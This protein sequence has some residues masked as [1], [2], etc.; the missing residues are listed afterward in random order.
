MAKQ[1]IP[2]APMPVPPI[3]AIALKLKALGYDPMPLVSGKDNPFKGWPDNPNTPDDI[4]K[5]NGRTVAL[6]TK[7]AAYLFYIDMDVQRQDL[8][9]A[10]LDKIEAR[11]PE[12]YERCVIRHSGA[13]K[14][15]LI[16]R[17][18]T[19]K[20]H[21]RTGRYGNDEEYPGGHR[22]ELFTSNDTRYVAVWG[23]HSDGRDYGFCEGPSL[24]E[25]KPDQL[26]W[27]KDED[28]SELLDMTEQV[29]IDAGLPKDESAHEDLDEVLYNLTPDIV[30]S[31]K[32]GRTMT[33]GD[34]D[35][36]IEGMVY[37]NSETLAP[38]SNSYRLKAAR[39]RSMGLTI[40][41][42]GNG[43][44]YHWKDQGPQ[45]ETL[46]P[47]LKQL[48]V[49]EAERIAAGGGDG[50]G[51]G[52]GHQFFG[53]MGPGTITQD[54]VAMAFAENFGEKL[55]YCHDTG[56]WYQ[57]NEVYWKPERTKLAFQYCR[58][59]GRQLSVQSRPTELKEVRKVGFA[60]GVERFAQADRRMATTAERWDRDVFLMGT[61]DGT[62]DLRT[63]TLRAPR[64][65][66]GI[67]RLAAVSPISGRPT[68]LWDRFLMETFQNDAEL[69]AFAQQW[70][71][72]CL[73]GDISEH[74]LWF[75][76]GEGG[77]GKGVL[78]NTITGIM[79]DYAVTATMDV[80]VASRNE[81]HSTELA[82]LQGARLVTASE[83]EKGRAWAEARIKQ[84]T[85][86]D[87]ITARFMRQD[88]FTFKPQFKL[89]LIGNHKPLL[90]GIDA[91]V[92]RRFNLVP[93]MNKPAVVDK[94]L[95]VKLRAEW[96]G[97]MAWLVRGCQQ[98]Q[99]RGLLRPESVRRATES[100]FDDQDI[101][102]QW[103]AD[104]CE[105]RP[106]RAVYATTAMLFASWQ[107]Y[108]TAA[109]EPVGNRKAFATEL[110][111]RGFEP[112]RDGHSKVR[113]LR[114]IRLKADAAG[115]TI[116]SIVPKTLDDKPK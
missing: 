113:S 11:W 81:R 94:K 52:A 6:R 60:G 24:L 100:Y 62:L 58:E 21:M 83:T 59:L 85:G 10:M 47:L 14:L 66:D 54:G 28:L 35:D 67:T 23:R 79:G 61:P 48:A 43:S 74:A 45:L 97:I 27:F 76:F 5:W 8:L 40:W 115:K 53:T 107:R 3:R 50:D 49:T 22:V 93:F 90:R 57:W 109:G 37:M 105:V 116:L 80:F 72:Y 34:L 17:L 112:F 36:E 51:A 87:P 101:T 75:G 110:A 82:M 65:E 99:Q 56:R 68:P 32:D 88:N 70:F 104:E 91:A 41:D 106:S 98:W 89:T 20:K 26:P 108:A 84:L 38:G 30:V 46:A 64:V 44:V 29:L 111:Q 9:D 1:R 77:N 63:G 16:G 42:F 55:K 102:G 33:L 12:F 103:I 4:A 13:V 86:G 18:K 19:D 31:L 95:E 25:G 39:T 7:D 2:L 73:T 78:I 71:G 96:P 92:K 114:G 69:I 15:C